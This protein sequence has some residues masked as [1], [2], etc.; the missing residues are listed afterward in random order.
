MEKISTV[1]EDD[2]TGKKKFWG[3]RKKSYSLE[4]MEKEEIVSRRRKIFEKKKEDSVKKTTQMKKTKNAR[5]TPAS[6]RKKKISIR[7]AAWDVMEDQE[8]M[9]DI[10]RGR[11]VQRME[12]MRLCSTR[13]SRKLGRK[14]FENLKRDTSLIEGASPPPSNGSTYGLEEKRSGLVVLTGR[15]PLCEKAKMEDAIGS[16]WVS[17]L[18]GEGHSGTGQGVG[19][20]ME[21]YGWSMPG[22]QT[23]PRPIQALGGGGWLQHRPSGGGTAGL[24]GE[25]PHGTSRGEGTDYTSC[26]DRKKAGD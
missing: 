5:K 10:G 9:E 25:V 21:P 26:T 3:G 19:D 15:K 11:S 17:G 23:K 6:E 8:S 18:G 4:D 12:D 1:K 13:S 22:C 14:L 2:H 24:G 7:S 20:K 16:R